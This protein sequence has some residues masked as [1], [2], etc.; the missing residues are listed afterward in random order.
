M[1][2]ATRLDLMQLRN[3]LLHQS[4]MLM[5][6]DQL[7]TMSMIVCSDTGIS[8]GLFLVALHMSYDKFTSFFRVKIMVIELADFKC[9]NYA[10][11]YKIRANW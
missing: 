2:T 4:P 8:C 7:L 5:H 9:I 6:A 3:K 10:P 11:T 1:L